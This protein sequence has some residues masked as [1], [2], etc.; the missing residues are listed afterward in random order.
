M[1][2]IATLPPPLME[3]GKAALVLIRDERNNGQ[4]DFCSANTRKYSF[5]AFAAR[6]CCGIGACS[7]VAFDPDEKDAALIL[8]NL[9]TTDNLIGDVESRVGRASTGKLSAEYSRRFH[10]HNNSPFVSVIAL[11]N[12]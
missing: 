10:N 2:V 3:S 8:G 7:V 5:A 9:V 1:R 4:I 12:F 11:Q 6:S